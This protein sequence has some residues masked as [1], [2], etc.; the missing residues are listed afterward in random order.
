MPSQNNIN[1]LEQRPCRGGGLGFTYAKLE[2]RFPWWK[3]C[4]WIAAVL[5]LE[6]RLA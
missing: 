3:H 5:T 4:C 6:F 2:T 1:F